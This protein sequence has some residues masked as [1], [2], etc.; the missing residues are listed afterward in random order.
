[1][2]QDGTA[3]LFALYN[4][5]P[6][7]EET[8]LFQ[9]R[10]SVSTYKGGSQIHRFPITVSSRLPGL[11]EPRARIS[12]P[13][14]HRESTRTHIQSVQYVQKGQASEFNATSIPYKQ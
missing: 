12:R 13:C 9:F 8:V 6:A 10:L 14:C 4:V 11:G 3:F 2:N 1:M 5:K 7:M